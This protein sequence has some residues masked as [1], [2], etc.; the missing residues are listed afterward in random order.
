M[1]GIIF[2]ICL[3]SVISAYFAAFRNSAWLAAH[4]T[5]A[6]RMQEQDGEDRIVAK[7]KPTTM[8]LAFSV[9]TSSFDCCRIRLRRKARGYSKH[10]V[11]KIGQVQGNY[12][13][14]IQSRRFSR[15]A[16]RCSSGCRYEETRYG[17]RR[18]G[19]PEIFLKIQEV[20]GN[21]SLEETQ[22]PKAVSKIW[23]HNLQIS[24]NY[25]PHME[26]VFSILRQRYGLGPMDQM[27]HLDVNTAI[28]GIYLSVTLQA[29][30]HLGIDYT[31]NLRSATNK[32]K[33]SFRLS[34]DSEVDHWPD[35]NYR[36]CNDWLAAAHVERRDSADWQ[37]CSVC[38][39]QNFRLFLTQC[40][41]WEVSVLNQTKHGKARLKW[42]LETRF[43][44][45]LD[46][47]DG[48]VSK[49]DDWIKMWGHFHW[50]QTAMQGP[51]NQRS[52]SK[53]AK[54]TCKKTV[55]RAY[56]DHWKW[57]QTYPSRATSPTKG[58]IN[59]LKALRNMHIDLMLLQDDDT[60]LLPQ[61]IRLRKP[62]RG[63]GVLPPQN[64]Q[65]AGRRVAEHCQE[66][67]INTNVPKFFVIAILTVFSKWTSPPAQ[68]FR[69]VLLAVT[70]AANLKQTSGWDLRTLWNTLSQ[71][72]RQSQTE[73]WFGWLTCK[74]GSQLTH[75]LRWESVQ[76]EGNQERN[77]KIRY[78]ARMIGHR[79]WRATR[80]RKVS[81]FRWLKKLLLQNIKA[82]RILRISVMCCGEVWGNRR[83][84]PRCQT[85]QEDMLRCKLRRGTSKC[86]LRTET[87]LQVQRK[88]T[89]LSVKPKGRRWKQ[90]KR[91]AQILFNSW[92]IENAVQKIAD[93][94]RQDRRRMQNI[95]KIAE[96]D[97]MKAKEKWWNGW[98]KKRNPAVNKR[99]R[100]EK[101]PIK[102]EPNFFE[103]GV[104]LRENALN[105]E[106]LRVAPQRNQGGVY[107]CK[108]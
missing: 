50:M 4:Q 36:N 34:S 42:Y 81:I 70:V 89:F 9:S 106:V 96:E 102:A 17:R 15:M 19:T 76:K 105:V 75:T 78:E 103:E 59:N 77:Q 51:L 21:S 45:D 71:G 39:C 10:L 35:W 108:S 30:V 37:S 8:N 94:M 74:I 100:E 82:F 86:T 14:K 97:L 72:D 73:S 43:L 90:T 99:K 22:K 91:M 12:K 53:H 52:D 31:E 13:H 24:T 18:P 62:T 28:W 83:S 92:R 3:T 61:P 20:Q 40:Y 58:A 67:C 46:R 104:E 26:M 16:K 6:K 60:I 63:R 66:K 44:Q 88:E 95:T 11:E 2:L 79:R 56:S 48:W 54:Q 1:S 23:P 25:V 27:K 47:I 93:L 55:P 87:H 64:E 7:S 68:G 5:M 49:D 41:V 33:K 107:L 65:E 98:K 84:K 32:P 85:V 80:R 101:K 38:N 69:N 57:K 29:T